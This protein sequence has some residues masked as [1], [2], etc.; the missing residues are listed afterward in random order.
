MR[1]KRLLT[2]VASIMVLGFSAVNSPG[3][4]IKVGL[5]STTSRKE[6]FLSDAELKRLVK[7]LKRMRSEPATVPGK[8][9]PQE[10]VYYCWEYG[11]ADRNFK[12]HA[13]SFDAEGGSA[14]CKISKHDSKSI[15][16]LSQTLLKRSK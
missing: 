2:A 14:Q 3:S 13:I 11:K 9:L 12:R 16:A 5:F 4:E 7:I 15:A 8:A 1:F 10:F 6:C